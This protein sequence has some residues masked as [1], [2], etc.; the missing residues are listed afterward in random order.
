MPTADMTPI[1][2]E[3]PVFRLSGA[4]PE[5][6]SL[7]L[8]YYEQEKGAQEKAAQV[9][10]YTGKIRLSLKAADLIII[11]LIISDR[12]I[13]RLNRYLFTGKTGAV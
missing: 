9:V 1:L 2:P 11:V 5:K 8:R 10:C 12:N 6:K 7:T 4:T 13:S 3:F